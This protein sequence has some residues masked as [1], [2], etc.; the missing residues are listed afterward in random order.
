MKG[1]DPTVIAGEEPELCYRLRRQNWKIYRFDQKMTLHDANITCFSQW[2]KRSVR[3]G[4]AYAQGFALHGRDG[5]H[6]CVKSSLRIWLWAIVIPI[7]VSLCAVIVD[8]AFLLFFTIYP[9]QFVKIAAV[10]NQQI[11]N[12]NYSFF[13]AL[14][15]IVG[16]WPELIGQILFIKRKILGKKYSIIEYN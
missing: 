5:Q 4:H 9:I 12:W 3:S 14:F 7:I 2:W 1:F 15:T 16:K 10:A 8:P 6:Y 11:D 13:Y